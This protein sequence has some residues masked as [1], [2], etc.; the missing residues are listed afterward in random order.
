MVPCPEVDGDAVNESV[1]SVLPDEVERLP[2]LDEY[3][4]FTLQYFSPKISDIQ[5]S[6]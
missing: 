1:W 6:R 4:V 5:Y 3:T 2:V